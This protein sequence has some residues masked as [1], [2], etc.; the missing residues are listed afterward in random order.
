MLTA[1]ILLATIQTAPDGCAVTPSDS[2]PADMRRPNAVQQ[3]N[4][5]A[6]SRSARGWMAHTVERAATE[7]DTE[8]IAAVRAAY[9]A[10]HGHQPEPVF[11]PRRAWFDADGEETF[12]VFASPQGCTADQGPDYVAALVDRDT[13]EVRQVSGDVVV[14]RGSYRPVRLTGGARTQ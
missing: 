3:W 11:D 6:S 4:D 1:L 14:V 9:E 12:V 13:G 10:E 8:V 5:W 2:M 7:D